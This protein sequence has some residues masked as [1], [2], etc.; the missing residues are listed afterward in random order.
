MA[1]YDKVAEEFWDARFSV[2][3]WGYKKLEQICRN[4]LNNPMYVGNMKEKE[5]PGLMT[6]HDEGQGAYTVY[7]PIPP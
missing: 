5:L 6:Y 4:M 3:M 1:L 2:N 7:L